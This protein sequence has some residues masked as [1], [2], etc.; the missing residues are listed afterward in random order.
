MIEDKTVALAQLLNDASASGSLSRLEAEVLM[1]HAIE[2]PRSYLFAW[3]EYKLTEQQQTTFLTLLERHRQGEPVAY[4]IGRREFWSL[5]LKV[6]PAT[7]IPRPE[8]EQLVE[9]ALALLQPMSQGRIADLGTG[10]GAIAAALA[11]ERPDSSI[12][13]TDQSEAA[14]E[15]ARFNFDNLGLKN[16]RTQSGSWF[17]ALPTNETFDL[18]ISNPPYIAEQD[19]HLLNDG[20]PWEPGSALVSGTDG[21]DDIKHLIER[22]PDHLNTQGWLILEHGFDQGEAVRALFSAAG[23]REVATHPDLER[24]DRITEGRKPERE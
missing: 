6:T 9:R 8:T 21:L 14:L 20:L 17:S 2:K 15:V 1:S 10:S 23:Y 16:I 12:V 19:P 11:S 7:L 5:S 3:P 18:I 24:R 22:A 4:I 13:A